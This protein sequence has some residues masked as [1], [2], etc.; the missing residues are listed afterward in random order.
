MEFSLVDT[1]QNC[2]NEESSILAIERGFMGKKEKSTPIDKKS[3]RRNCQLQA[4]LRIV[5]LSEEIRTIQAASARYYQPSLDGRIW[6]KQ[7]RPDCTWIHTIMRKENMEVMPC[8]NPNNDH[9]VEV[10]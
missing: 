8:T 3:A 1:E 4:S 6:M 9:D 10:A 2:R 7:G 5:G